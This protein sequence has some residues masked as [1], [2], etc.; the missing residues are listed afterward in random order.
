MK[1]VIP[2]VR[3]PTI[4]ISLA[5]GFALG[6]I[7]RIRL[8]EPLPN[9]LLQFFGT[10]ATVVGSIGGA[11]GL[12]WW[13]QSHRAANVKRLFQSIFQSSA[14]YIEGIAINVNTDPSVNPVLGNRRK[15]QGLLSREPRP[16][17]PG[18]EGLVE[19]SDDE[20]L[21]AESLKSAQSLCADALSLLNKSLQ[22]YED[23]KQLLPHLQAGDVTELINLRRMAGD[24]LESIKAISEATPGRAME[25]PAASQVIAL[26]AVLKEWMRPLRVSAK[27]QLEKSPKSP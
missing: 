7:V 1:L 3:W 19:M 23:L 17:R 11:L 10:L 9:D 13:Q 22:D 21:Y 14:G 4:L 18:I 12:W 26:W 20:V 25:T 5:F 16:V 8:L 6:L 2:N 27:K 15:Y 24:S